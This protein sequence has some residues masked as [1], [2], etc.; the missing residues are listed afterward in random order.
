MSMGNSVQAVVGLSGFQTEAEGIP[1]SREHLV[2]FELTPNFTTEHVA[3]AQKD[4]EVLA[5]KAAEHPGELAEFHNAVLAHDLPRAQR[6][7]EEIGL[8]PAQIHDEAGGQIVVAVGVIVILVAAAYLL[9]GDSPPPPPPPRTHP[10][11]GP[12]PMDAGVDG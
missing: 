1:M 10:D 9:S 5:R 3:L 7:A 8:T 6:L 12:P 11:A 2:R 4:F